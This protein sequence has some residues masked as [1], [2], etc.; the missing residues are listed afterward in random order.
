VKTGILMNHKR[1]SCPH[2]IMK[3]FSNFLSQMNLFR[4]KG[5]LDVIAVFGLFVVS[6]VLVLGLMPFDSGERGRSLYLYTMMTIPILIAIYFIMIS[7][8]S[9]VK[10]GVRPESTLRAKF[11][12]I[13]IF[14]TAAP[15]IPVV[16]ISNTVIKKAVESVAYADVGESLKKAVDHSKQ[17]LVSIGD[18]MRNEMNSM[19]Y[20]LDR[21]IIYADSFSGRRH[22]SEIYRAKGILINFYQMRSKGALNDTIDDADG[23]GGSVY[24][25]GVKEFIALQNPGSG[26]TVSHIT[27]D[28]TPLIVGAFSRGDTIIVMFRVVPQEIFQ[29][30]RSFT[31]AH[32][33]Y[34]KKSLQRDNVQAIAGYLLLLV[35]IAVIVLSIG[36]SLYM[37]RTV[38]FPILEIADAAKTVASGN[39]DVNLVSRSDDE[40]ATLYRSFNSMTH[41]LKENRDAMYFAQKL[42]A[43]RE[44]SRKILHEIKNPLTPIRLSAERIRRHHNEKK[45]DLGS[46]IIKGTDTIIEEVTAI[47]R[48]LDEFTNFARLPEVNPEPNDLNHAVRGYAGFYQGFEHVKFDLKLDET[49][50]AVL[51]DKLLLRQ[52]ALNIIKNAVEAMSGNGKIEIATGKISETTAFLSVKDFGPGIPPDDISRLFE[53]T[54]TRR[55]GGTGLGLSIVE[56]IALDHRGKVYCKSKVGEGSVFTIELPFAV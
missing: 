31:I 47:Q 12:L 50:P 45:E 27:V 1:F 23:S 9:S 46:A 15:L 13:F 51:F 37:S 6:A 5:M 21:G 20:W 32:E 14:V 54:F 56:K 36:L 10:K 44:V 25:S 35:S 19:S 11:T 34:T 26:G 30:I 39:F 43:W 7:F 22:L 4:R 38:T 18:G 2:V 49:L 29:R 40:I 42:N 16:L 53:P 52:A 41:Q 24:S 48:I 55:K 28:N 3:L 8:R 33:R 17:E